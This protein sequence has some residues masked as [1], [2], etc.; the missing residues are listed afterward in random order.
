[1]LRQSRLDIHMRMSMFT[2]ISPTKTLL[3]VPLDDE[4]KDINNELNAAVL[5][6]LD[7]RS[8]DSVCNILLHYLNVREHSVIRTRILNQEFDNSKYLDELKL[9]GVVDLLQYLKGLKGKQ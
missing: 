3:S 2:E 1:M 6:V 4:I 7:D 8:I 9:A 5:S